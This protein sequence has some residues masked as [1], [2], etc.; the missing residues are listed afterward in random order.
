M[1]RQYHKMAYFTQQKQYHQWT[2]LTP[3]PE[4]RKKGML[5]DQLQLLR[6]T[7]TVLLCCWGRSRL[8]I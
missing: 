3:D 5:S 4:K 6:V 8:K 1:Q 7:S 2:T